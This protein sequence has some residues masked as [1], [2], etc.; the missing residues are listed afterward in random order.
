MWSASTN[1]CVLPWQP[2]TVIN[3]DRKPRSPKRPPWSVS[4]STKICASASRPDRKVPPRGSIERYPW[5]AYYEHLLHTPISLGFGDHSFSQTV[6]FWINDVLMVVFF[7]VVGLEVRRELFE[8]QLSEL[9]RA[10]LPVAAALGGM[11][12]PAVIYLSLNLGSDSVRGWGI[13]MAT[14]I[15]FAVGVLALLGRRVP[16]ALRVLLLA[17]AIIDDIGAILVIALFYSAGI[18]WNGLAAGAIGIAIVLMMQRVGVRNSF[19]YMMP[20]VL[21]WG[22]ILHAGIHPTIA[23]VILG[24]LTPAR[25]WFGHE[26]FRK[27]TEHALSSLRDM[28][29]AELDPRRLLPVIERVNVASREAIPPVTRIEAALHPWVAFGI[30]PLFALANAGVSFGGIGTGASESTSI[31]LGI[32]VGLVL[33]KPLGVVSFSWLAVRFNLASLPRG[34]S[35]GGIFVIGCVA[36]I[37]FTMAL[38]IAA[39]A[40][41]DASM[42][43]VAKLAVL[44]ASAVAGIA[45][46]VIGFRVLP[47]AQEKATT[48]VNVGDEPG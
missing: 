10:A 26:G 5:G 18:A 24:L 42:L 47:V 44:L 6:H 31:A 41:T 48:G 13:P 4:A 34:V 39:L 2:I 20:G 17:L 14:D 38:F 1:D 22:G 37:G 35:W 21:V 29:A 11:L 19:L 12:V 46:I 27:E 33:G 15:A 45:T 3:N 40:F 9:R 30:M 32:G 36:G 28:A 25:S 43:S 16:S 7:F 8:G 23:G